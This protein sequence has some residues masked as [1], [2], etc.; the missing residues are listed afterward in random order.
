[1]HKWIGLLLTVCVVNT[2]QAETFHVQKGDWTAKIQVAECDEHICTGQSTIELNTG[3]YIQSFYQNDSSFYR[4]HK[5]EPLQFDD[6]LN[7]AD[8]NFDG[9]LDI[10]ISQGNYGSYGSP[11]YDIYL[12]TQSGKFVLN[13]ELT[14][15]ASSDF[16][17]LPEVDIENRL[18]KVFR[19]VGY[20]ER[21][22]T[23]Y[24]VRQNQRPALQQI[25]EHHTEFLLD[26]TVR[27]SITF[28][29]NGK[30]STTITITTK[31]F[32]HNP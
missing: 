15:L 1:M 18:L 20:S 22:E 13:N 12:Q 2:V 24:R 10:A 27:E 8:Y 19:K 14:E 25:Y 17:G 5:N 29:K 21:I 3:K 26:D 11:I 28:W 9:L 23:H 7:T 31:P 4:K 32:N 16:I 6:F 30:K